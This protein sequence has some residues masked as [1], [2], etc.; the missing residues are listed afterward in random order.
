MTAKFFEEWIKELDQQF[1][2]KNQHVGLTLDNFPGHLIT[3]EPTNIELIYFKP[4]L[5]PYGQPLDAEIICCVKAHHQRAFCIG[6]VDLDEAG[7]SDI[8]KINLLEVMLIIRQAWDVVTQET[9]ANCWRYSG[10]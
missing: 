4:N 5:T 2:C 9:I 1:Q 10:I 7:E 6:A 8:Y 3:Y